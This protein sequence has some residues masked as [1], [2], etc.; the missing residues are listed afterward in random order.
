MASPHAAAA[1]SSEGSTPRGTLWRGCLLLGLAL[2]VGNGPVLLAGRTWIPLVPSLG[3]LPLAPYGYRGPVPE[4]EVTG[5]PAGAFNADLAFDAYL[6]ASLK[7]GSFPFWNPYQGLGQPF[8]ANG[9]AGALYPINWLH[10]VLPPEWWDLVYLANWF[11]AA[12]LLYGYLRVL[13]LSIR[14]AAVGGVAVLGSAYFQIY[15]AL[16]EVTAGAAWWPLLLGGIE[17]AIRRPTWPWRHALLATPVYATLSGGQPEVA[18]FSLATAT[19][20]GLLRVAGQRTARW[21]TLASL[22]PGSVAGLLLAAPTWLPF[23]GYLRTAYTAHPVGSAYGD[24]HLPL[25]SVATYVFPGLY[26]LLHSHPLGDVEGWAWNHSPGWVPALVLFLALRGGW[27]AVRSRAAQP[28]FFGTVALVV[29]AKTWGVPPV[30]QLGRLPVVELLIFP[31]YAGFLLVLSIAGLAA[32]GSQGLSALDARAWRRWTVAWCSL[33]SAVL[34]LGTSP[35]WSRPEPEPLRHLAIFGGLGLAWA[36]LGPLGLCR[37][38]RHRSAA[39]G[40]PALVAATGILLQ[41]A[42]HAPHGHSASLVAAA[43]LAGLALHLLLSFVL[44]LRSWRPRRSLAVGGASISVLLHA[45]L[46]LAVSSSG[47]P[48]RHDPLT[49]APYLHVMALLQES[50]R[51]RSYSLDAMP[52]PNFAA[53]FALSSLNVI[54]ALLPAG[55]AAFFRRCLDRGADPILFGGRLSIGR[56]PRF[57][58]GSELRENQRFFDLVGVRH[59]TARRHPAPGFAPET[60]TPVYAD[61]TGVGIWENRSALPRA[62]LAPTAL[63]AD[64]GEAALEN[65]ARVEDPTRTVWIEA[66]PPIGE[67]KPGIDSPGRLLEFRLAPNDVWIEYEAHTQGLLTLTDSWSEGW[68]AEVNGEDVPVLRVDG[69]FRGVRLPRSGR[70]EVHFWY[71]PPEWRLSLGLAGFGALLLAA[72][73]LVDGGLRRRWPFLRA[74]HRPARLATP[75]SRGR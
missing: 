66:G 16:R 10:V 26:G 52:H 37:V 4:G 58:A 75:R 3:V 18:F 7:R 54:E 24:I 73:A 68:R 12:A 15:L 33:A 35:V 53:P 67:G 25:S 9:L 13:G 65:L 27:M 51:F 2:L 31:R 64:S 21:A 45:G 29:A 50:N 1:E 39:S 36:V 28:V 44:G 43:S 60:L 40:A 11:L 41:A 38:A 34:L 46:P 8:L 49:R 55:T 19:A 23:A 74:A 6:A 5:D 30:H 17:V 56:D 59:V 32:Y 22:A 69:V 72:G 20:Y 62:F 61:A 70:H 63:L 71:R 14:S 57:P 47:L 48:R 42:A